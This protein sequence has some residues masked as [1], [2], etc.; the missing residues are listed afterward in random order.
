MICY[1][2]CEI[3]DVSRSHNS[4]IQEKNVLLDVKYR[5][6]YAGHFEGRNAFSLHMLPSLV[7]SG[8]TLYCKG[9]Y[10]VI[11][12]CFF[13]EHTFFLCCNQVNRNIPYNVCDYQNHHFFHGPY[14]RRTSL[15]FCL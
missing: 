15:M 1:T 6:P 9:S 10:S 11:V 12:C 5:H 4:P 3:L 7:S 14:V 13:S 8:I 2:S